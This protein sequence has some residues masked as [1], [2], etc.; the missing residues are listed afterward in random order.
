MEGLSPN[1]VLPRRLDV[2]ADLTKRMHALRHLEGLLLQKQET[3]VTQ[4]KSILQRLKWAAGANP[5]L[6]SVLQEVESNIQKRN[7]VMQKEAALSAK[8][9]ELCETAVE[10]EQSRIKVGGTAG[11]NRGT[12]GEKVY[13]QILETC[14]Q[15]SANTA[16]APVK[17]SQSEAA[18]VNV[19][20][21]K[22]KR[23][24]ADD[25]LSKA[26]DTLQSSTSQLRQARI[27]EEVKM[28]SV[29]S[30]LTSTANT[31]KQLLTVHS[32]LLSDVKNLLKVL[33]KDDKGE[34]KI[35]VAK[36]AE[37]AVDAGQE[38]ESGSVT[39]VRNFLDEYK[40]FCAKLNDLLRDVLQGCDGSTMSDP[41]PLIHRLTEIILSV[42]KIYDSL[43]MLAA[44]LPGD[45]AQTQPSFATAL[46]TGTQA[47]N[48]TLD[49]DQ[50]A[51]AAVSA[52][53][54]SFGNLA[55]TDGAGGKEDAANA[56]AVV[57][58]AR[59]GGQMKSTLS[60]VQIASMTRAASPK[61]KVQDPRTGK[62]IQE[63]N[64]FAVSVWRRVK[65]KLDGRDVDFSR[66]MQISEQVD[67]VINEAVSLDNLALLYE[68]WTAWV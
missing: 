62:A 14:E 52:V 22:S 40:S 25:W 38:D 23:A 11:G 33:A 66:R 67:Y 61:K 19:M 2:I 42:A 60:E 35:Q 32:R 9:R 6:Q 51:K 4:N 21:S 13:T 24:L 31:V 47:S 44:P 12:A 10:F 63:R 55:V 15:I 16:H 48:Q 68:G 50:V 27:Q 7:A 28:Q 30:K 39:S 29:K 65:A 1:F 58:G 59:T 26:G 8:V 49:D 20:L 54:N 46:R 3:A 5:T 36:N 57:N 64:C 53:Q 37:A 56:P 18:L 34:N 43:V 17:I 45:K 41:D